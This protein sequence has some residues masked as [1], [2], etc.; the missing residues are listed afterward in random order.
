[1][2]GFGQPKFEVLFLEEARRFLHSLDP[3]TR[4]KVLFDIDRSRYLNDAGLF[5]K[6][7]EEIWEFRTRYNRNQYRIL[8]FWLKVSFVKVVV[9][10]HGFTKKSDKVPQKEIS[11]ASNIRNRYLLS[12]ENESQG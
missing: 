5:K 11:K 4:K 10:T 3:K 9:A 2:Q 1:M 12:I 8:A 6:L 7:T